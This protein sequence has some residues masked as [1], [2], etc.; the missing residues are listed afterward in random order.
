MNIAAPGG[1]M[2]PDISQIVLIFVAGFACA[3]CGAIM[4]SHLNLRARLLNLYRPGKARPGDEKARPGDEDEYAGCTNVPDPKKILENAADG[5]ITLDA[6]GRIIDCNPAFT[7]LF[8]FERARALGQRAHDILVPGD[9]RNRNQEY[10]EKVQALDA[11]SRDFEEII[12]RAMTASGEEIPVTV[13]VGRFAQGKDWYYVFTVRNTWRTRKSIRELVES[14]E[15]VEAAR[16]ITANFLA[17]MS[18][19]IRTPLNSIL[20][21]LE[22]LKNTPLSARQANF[23]HTAHGAAF[24]LRQMLNEILEMSVLERRA[25]EAKSEP[26]MVRELMQEVFA[27]FQASSS[28]RG[29]QLNMDIAP[30]VGM[31]FCGDAGRIRRVLVNLVGNAIKFTPSGSVS[32]R[33]KTQ[34]PQDGDGTAMLRFEVEDTGPGVPEALRASLFDEFVSGIPAADPD[35]PGAG[36]GLAICLE[37][38]RLMGGGI[39]LARNGPGGACFVLTLPLPAADASQ[40]VADRQVQAFADATLLDGAHILLAEDNATNRLITTEIL[41]H[42]NC[43]VSAVSDGEAVLEVLDGQRCDA[44]L[45]DVSMPRLNGFETARRIRARRDANASIPIIALTAYSREHGEESAKNAGI[46]EFIVK[47]ARTDELIGVLSRRIKERRAA[48]QGEPAGTTAPAMQGHESLPVLDVP[49]LH[50]MIDDLPAHSIRRV[51]TGL[52]ADFDKKMDT[53]RGAGGDNAALAAAAHAIK[54]LAATFGAAR[55]AAWCRDIQ[56]LFNDG[57]EIPETQIDM[58]CDLAGQSSRAII[59]ELE[60]ILAQQDMDEIAATDSG[61]SDHHVQSADNQVSGAP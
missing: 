13:S 59:I 28:E 24:S 23:I 32:L 40:I 5:I 33:L 35:Q 4:C 52:Q 20:G 46:D 21:L 9:L 30:D 26:F 25:G 6:S 36:L 10:W 58:I 39:E 51:A 2:D 53:L 34:A 1:T 11:H 57:K 7:R 31:A 55:L 56:E 42:W 38:G 8:G 27:L 3:A 61:D 29:L 17:I 48:T 41:T 50:S 15:R 54:G 12:G 47:P 19:E 49:M 18:H 14:R 16:R 45:V 44:V 22:L 60:Q 37:L 43:R